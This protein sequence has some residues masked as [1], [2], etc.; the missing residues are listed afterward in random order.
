MIK[1]PKCNVKINT[2]VTRCPLC[3]NPLKKGEGIDVFPVTFFDYKKHNLF[4]KL[5]FAL[6]LIASFISL[7]INF[8]ISK[9]LSWAYFVVLA[10]ISFW[11]TLIEAIRGCKNFVRMLFLEMIIILFLSYLWERIFSFHG[12]CLNYCLPFLC[13]L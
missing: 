8:A 12:L 4:L 9:K 1:C 10:I 11:L 3:N 5:L 7:F 6:S 13:V 2:C